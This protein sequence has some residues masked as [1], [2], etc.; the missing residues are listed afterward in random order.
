MMIKECIVKC[1]MW[2]SAERD[3]FWPAAGWL[4][5]SG[6]L[7]GI[8]QGVTRQMGAGPAVCCADGA[9]G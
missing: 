8:T 4:P 6:V 9:A 7:D 3:V 5:Q 2:I 1:L